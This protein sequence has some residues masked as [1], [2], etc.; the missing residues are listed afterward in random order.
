[1][2]FLIKPFLCYCFLN[3][4]FGHAIPLV[5][6]LGFTSVNEEILLGYAEV[7][8]GRLDHLYTIKIGFT[9][10]TTYA[11][12]FLYFLGIIRLYASVL[13]IIRIS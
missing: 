13:F 4:F 12:V 7:F 9:T 1:M 11:I 3:P 5:A 6:R 10:F 2:W 8:S